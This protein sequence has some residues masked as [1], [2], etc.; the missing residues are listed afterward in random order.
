[1]R[2][3]VDREFHPV[4]LVHRQADAVHRDGTLA[5]DVSREL[6]RRRHREQP[7]VAR[8]LEP[9]HRTHSVHMAAH[10]VAAEP[11]GEPQRL[12]QIDP[13][14]CRYARGAGQRLLRNVRLELAGAARDHGEAHAV[15]GDAVAG[16]DIAEIEAAG[17]YAQPQAARRG[18][19]RGHLAD[20]RDHPGKHYTNLAI[21]RISAP[22]MRRSWI[23]N[24]RRPARSVSSGR[25]NIPR[26]A[27][28]IRLG[29][30]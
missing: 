16:R 6:A 7:V 13:A 1:M 9:R 19:R 12:L 18:R 14:A 30:R 3:Q 20:R 17:G 24:S 2:Y 26:A 29:A 23:F 8:R 4:H 22:I 27:S 15:H 11:V 10:Q 5:G 28:P 21:T 25:L